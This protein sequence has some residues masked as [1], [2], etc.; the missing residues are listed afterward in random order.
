[1]SLKILNLEDFKDTPVS[2]DTGALLHPPLRTNFD[3]LKK[4]G[5][6]DKFQLCFPCIA[7]LHWLNTRECKLTHD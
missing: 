7:G 6:C 4:P 2:D 5:Y 1:M 3:F